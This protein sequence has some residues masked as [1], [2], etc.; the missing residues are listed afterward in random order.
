MS[1]ARI[2][3]Y[4]AKKILL[5]DTY[6]GI[7]VTSE[8]DLNQI[9]LNEEFDEWAVKVDDGKKQRKKN[10]LVML[11]LNSKEA[12][13]CAYDYINQ[14]FHRVLLEPMIKHPQNE[15]KYLSL[16]FQRNAVEYIFS[17]YGGIDV[18]ANK[19][20]IEKISIPYSLIRNENLSIVKKISTEMLLKLINFCTLHNVMFLEINPFIVSNGQMHCIDFA[21]EIDDTKLHLMPAWILEH[22]QETRKANEHE[23]LVDKI[24]STSNATFTLSVFDSNAPIF[25]ILSGGGASLV[26][27]DEL[28]NLGLKDKIANY[29]EYS[30]APSVDETCVFVTEILKILFKSESSKKIL[31]I[32]GGVANFTDISVTCSGIIKACSNFLPLFEEQNVFV[33]VRRGGPGQEIGLESLRNFFTKN[34]ISAQVFGSEVSISE[35]V[36]K[37]IV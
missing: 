4:A 1:R 21:L 30:G 20:S 37:I 29:S 33:L 25:T 16:D 18:E 11:S 6:P 35:I 5:G 8:T 2:S 12:K 34:N 14:G 9:D 24:N 32:G 36:A 28:V 26:F 7:S 22:V 19:Q 17:E 23:I 13:R 27:I 31:L 10:G 3:E 15:E